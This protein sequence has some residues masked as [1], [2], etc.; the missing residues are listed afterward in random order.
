MTDFKEIFT[1][2]INSFWHENKEIIKLKDKIKISLGLIEA[3]KK[4]I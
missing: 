3:I 4:T 2:L 1:I